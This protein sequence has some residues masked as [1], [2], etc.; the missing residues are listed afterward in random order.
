VLSKA[1]RAVEIEDA[2]AESEMGEMSLN[3]TDQSLVL[4]SKGK[5]RSKRIFTEETGVQVASEEQGD[6]SSSRT[7][8]KKVKD[9]RTWLQ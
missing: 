6:C 7:N 8:P 4:L 9:G 1:S 5:G 3:P 2:S